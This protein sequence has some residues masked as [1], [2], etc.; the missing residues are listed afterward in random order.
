MD[1]RTS[2]PFADTAALHFPTASKSHR[3]GQSASGDP[4]YGRR[5]FA[6]LCARFITHLFQCPDLPPTTG[7]PFDDPPIPLAKFIAYALHRSNVNESVVFSALYL[8]QRLKIRF[9][10]AKDCDGMAGH[11]MFLPALRMVSQSRS[12]TDY[13]VDVGQGLFHREQVEGGE[14]DLR[15]FLSNYVEIDAAALRE[16]ERLVRRDFAGR[17]PY[18]NYAET[19]TSFSRRPQRQA[20]SIPAPIVVHPGGPL[21]PHTPGLSASTS[22]TP[23]MGMPVT[24]T[25]Y[26]THGA[27]TA[28]AQKPPTVPQ[29]G[30]IY[31][32]P[33]GYLW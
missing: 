8:L 31:A 9:P 14:R 22:T 28:R 21:G 12:S 1:Y 18:P 11:R 17:G 33:Q 19:H 6:K 24:P 25:G 20:T 15:Y 29:P 30:L 23:V 7:S 4:Y 3:A 27:V 26:P 2:N 13:W 32:R 16:F 10:A 5:D